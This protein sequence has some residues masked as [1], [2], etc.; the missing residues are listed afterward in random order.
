[1]EEWYGEQKKTKF[2]ITGAGLDMLHDYG[3]FSWAVCIGGLGASSISCYQCKLWVHKKCSGIKGRLNVTPNYVCPRCL[4][5][6]P[7]L[8]MEDLSPK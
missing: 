7:A 2:M 8:L 6:R 4:D 1:M 5:L 3:A